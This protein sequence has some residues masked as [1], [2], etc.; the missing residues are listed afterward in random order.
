[1]G[2]K[3]KYWEATTK[4]ANEVT[5][6]WYK[7]PEFWVGFIGGIVGII[8][9]IFSIC[10]SFRTYNWSV[11]TYNQ[12]LP[13]QEANVIFLESSN[14]LHSQEG[15]Q[16]QVEDMIVS[17]D[18]I[19]PLIKN[20]GRATAKDISFKIYT[21]Y[22]DESLKFPSSGDSVEKFFDEKIVHD[23]PPDAVASFGAINLPH[24][25]ESCTRILPD[26]K[27]Q[28]ALISHLQFTDSLTGEIKDRIFLF[29]YS[30]GANQF[31]SLIGDDY[32]KIKDRLIKKIEEGGDDEKLLNFL[33][34]K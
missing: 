24:G 6:P 1:M 31:R 7:K 25:S 2:M 18:S 32:K 27:Q 34:S 12:S 20:I 14:I 4:M 28:V 17:F 9:G 16:A 23:L 19:E 3:E 10:W 26:E 33:K 30:I 15:E 29:Q 11:D 8:G 22:F 5:R 13:L 21:V